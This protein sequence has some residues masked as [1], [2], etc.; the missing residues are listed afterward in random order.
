[1]WGPSLEIVVNIRTAEVQLTPFYML[2]LMDVQWVY[3]QLLRVRTSQVP[4]VRPG[5]N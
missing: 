1:M 4:V 5:G 2:V 3:L